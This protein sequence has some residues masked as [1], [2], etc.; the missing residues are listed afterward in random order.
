MWPEPP[1]PVLCSS[2]PRS[3]TTCAPHNFWTK[4]P[5]YKIQMSK[6][7]RISPEAWIFSQIVKKGPFAPPPYVRAW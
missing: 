3:G 4:T 5:I 7:V 1:E 6:Q 2:S